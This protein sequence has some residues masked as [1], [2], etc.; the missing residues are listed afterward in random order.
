VFKLLTEYE[1]LN[2]TSKG[3]V[4]RKIFFI[5]VLYFNILLS[6]EKKDIGG[7]SRKKLFYLKNVKEFNV[8]A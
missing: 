6:I 1:I 2:H 7:Y 5:S 4:F 3:S 8:Y